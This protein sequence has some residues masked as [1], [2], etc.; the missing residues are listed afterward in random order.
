MLKGSVAMKFHSYAVAASI[1]LVGCATKHYP[2]ETAVAPAEAQ[3]MTCKDIALE[4]VKCD[5]VEQQIDATGTT[6][7]KSVMGFFGDFGIG[8]GMAKSDARAALATRRAGLHDAQL[9]HGC[10]N[11]ATAPTG[12]TEPVATSH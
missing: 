6:D 12:H 7:V 9:Q 10:V 2:I 5:Q 8:N 4:L 1:F 11:D 3:L